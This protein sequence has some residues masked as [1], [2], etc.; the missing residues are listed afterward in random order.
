MR[1]SV[2]LPQPEGPTIMKNS[3]GSMSTETWSMAVSLPNVLS[4]SRIRI[5]GRDACGLSTVR[6]FGTLRLMCRSS[7]LAKG[8]FAGQLARS[9]LAP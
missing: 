8:H 3:P 1:S 9:Q 7:P 6:R 4:R 5:A 2:V